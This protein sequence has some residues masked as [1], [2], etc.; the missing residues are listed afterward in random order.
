MS[1]L[2]VGSVTYNYPDQSSEPG[3]GTDAT[4]W[5]QAV[6][7]AL[8][9]LV[10]AGTINE[11]QATIEL[12]VTS[13]KPITAFVFNQALSKAATVTYRIQRTSSTTNLYEKGTIEITYDPSQSNPWLMSR[14]IDAGSDALVTMDLDNTGQMNYT[15]AVLSGTG[16]V[17]FIKFKTSSSILT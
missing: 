8:S 14:T 10:P 12:N 15:S 17:G 13:P 11:T 7:D 5:S 6:T 3:W 1:Q 9:S 16:Y 2:K 4:G